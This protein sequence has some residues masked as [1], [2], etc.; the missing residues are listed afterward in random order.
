MALGLWDPITIDEREVTLSSGD[1]LIMYT[2]GMTDCRSPEG[3]AFGLDRIKNLLS[4]L[5]K[6][7]AQQ[8]S[9]KLLETLQGYQNGAKQDDDVTLV[10]IKAK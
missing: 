8:V 10:T 7:N 1:T 5:T 2:D 4:E 9:D 3:E 6:L